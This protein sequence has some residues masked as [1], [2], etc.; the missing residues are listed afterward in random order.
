MIRTKTMFMSDK[1]SD[2][3]FSNRMDAMSAEMQQGNVQTK[4]M[5]ADH[6]EAVFSAIR[7]FEILRSRYL[8]EIEEVDAVRQKIRDTY[9]PKL[10]QLV[11]F[12]EDAMCDDDDTCSCERCDDRT[13]LMNL[14]Q[15]QDTTETQRRVTPRPVNKKRGLQ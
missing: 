13:C 4:S 14:C 11:E 10:K 9:A 6:V 1:I 7:E 8:K 12:L 5:D 2:T 15:K 3:L